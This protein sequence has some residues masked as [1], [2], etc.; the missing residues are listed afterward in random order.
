MSVSLV[1]LEPRPEW[2]VLPPSLKLRRTAVARSVEL[3]L[4]P[5]RSSFCVLECFVEILKLPSH[6]QLPRECD[7]APPT[8]ESSWM[9][10]SRAVA[11]ARGFRQTTRL[12]RPRPLFGLA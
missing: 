1:L 5:Q 10:Q 11:S 4:E 3:V 8:M 6:R 12:R 7:D 9:F 2:L